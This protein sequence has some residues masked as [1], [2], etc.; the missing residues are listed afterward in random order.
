MRTKKLRLQ[1]G[2]DRRTSRRCVGRPSVQGDQTLG[3]RICG[4]AEAGA[5]KCPRENR[6]GSDGAFHQVGTLPRTDGSR[7]T[8]GGR[9][10]S[11]RFANDAEIAQSAENRCLAEI[12]SRGGRGWVIDRRGRRCARDVWVSSGYAALL[13]RTTMTHW[14]GAAQY[15]EAES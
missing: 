10:N 8:G 12:S 3:G 7:R 14:W 15:A 1:R 9:R 13:L 6:L 11:E 2:S 4:V 5:P